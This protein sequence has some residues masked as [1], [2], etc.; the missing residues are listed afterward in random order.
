MTRTASTM[1]TQTAASR[2]AS[3]KTLYELREYVDPEIG[4]KIM[5]GAVMNRLKQSPTEKATWEAIKDT[6]N[7]AKYSGYVTTQYYLDEDQEDYGRMKAQVMATGVSAVPYMRMKRDARAHLA[8]KYYWD[9]DMVNCQPLILQHA[10]ERSNIKS[11]MLDRYIANRSEALAEVET[12]CN[13]TRAVAKQLFIRIMFYGGVQGWLDDNPTVQRTTVP[14]WIFK[15]KDEMRRN[16]ETLVTSVEFN[17]L[18]KYHARKAVSFEEGV[19]KNKTASLVALYLQTAERE[20]VSALVDAIQAEGRPIGAIIFDGVLVAKDANETIDQIPLRLWEK[21]VHHK[22]GYPVKLF[23]KTLEGD[24]A[25]LE[26]EQTPDDSI[27]SKWDD[28]WMEGTGMF[29][30]KEMKQLW[31]R[32]SFKVRRGGN[33]VREEPNGRDVMSEKQLIDA[34]RHLTYDEITYKNGEAIVKPRQFIAKWIDDKKMRIKKEIALRPPPLDATGDVYNIWTEPAVA[35]YR[36]TKEVDTDSEGVRM[37]LDFLH[38]LCGRV[39]GLTDYVIDWTAQLFQQFAVKTG[40]ALLL[41]GEEGVGKNRWTDLL[42]EMIGKDKFLQT[43]DPSNTLYGR[44]TRLREGKFLI[45]VNEASGKDNFAAQDK[46]KDMITCDQFVCEGKGTNAYDIE[47]YA[48]FIFTTNNDNCL[49]VNPDSRRYLVIDVSSEF[50]GNTDYFKR[51]SAV[52]NDEHTRYEFHRLLMERDIRHVDWINDRPVSS[53]HL[54]MASMNLACEEKFIK[55]YVMR[56][57]KED[58]FIAEYTVENVYNAFR[59]WIQTNNMED[60]LHGLTPLKFANKLSKYAWNA[61]THTGFKGLLKERKTDGV[62]YVFDVVQIAHEM[63]AKRW[64][65]EDDVAYYPEAVFREEAL[66]RV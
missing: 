12:A 49:K 28:A 46:L 47:C 42:R 7:V 27:D 33:Y 10:L 43:A 9:V 25:W 39:Q 3:R 44:F 24:P 15:L 38:G 5:E 4:A 30:Y 37:I 58:T 36:P 29:S 22:T 60:M 64:L 55:S 50:R 53:G 19:P 6:I 56:I 40:I 61:K 20:C 32:R 62:R 59:S 21:E 18:K 31:E 41:R 16:A 17:N 63:R 52:I 51:L 13:V 65:T 14:E 34:Y 66:A 54:E 48:R 2:I 11:P 26:P 35:K 8:S 45:V 1:S 57:A 23:V